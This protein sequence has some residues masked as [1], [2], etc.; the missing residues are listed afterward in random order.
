MPAFTDSLER[1]IRLAE[2]RE[3]RHVMGCHIEMS[4]TPGRDY[5]LG[6][7]YQPEEPPLQ[8]TV[9]QQLAAAALR[10]SPP[11]G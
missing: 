10:D 1:L 3:V 4:R 9:H 11:V 5:P 2:S 7:T 8:M 6:T